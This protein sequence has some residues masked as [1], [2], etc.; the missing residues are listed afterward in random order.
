MRLLETAVSEVRIQH[1][2]L[3]TLGSLNLQEQVVSTYSG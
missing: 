2:D 3:G 1:E